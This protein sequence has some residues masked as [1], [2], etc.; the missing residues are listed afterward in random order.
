MHIQGGHTHVWTRTHKPAAA[1]THSR[2]TAQQL[3]LPGVLDTCK[4]GSGG[5]TEGAKLAKTSSHHIT[6]TYRFSWLCRSISRFK[7]IA[8][9]IVIVCKH[10]VLR[11]VAL[12]VTCVAAHSVPLQR[13]SIPV[14]HNSRNDR[15]GGVALKRIR[16]YSLW[17]KSLATADNFRI[18]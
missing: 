7:L 15:F 8:S 10:V 12:Q 6:A 5:A 11:P 17:L 16:T 9:E 13:V 18:E 4:A 14:T 2:T 3:G 1:R